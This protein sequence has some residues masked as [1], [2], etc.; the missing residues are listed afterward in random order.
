MLK[1]LTAALAIGLAGLA[2]AQEGPFKDP[3]TVPALEEVGNEVAVDQ[4][5]FLKAGEADGL[6]YKLYSMSGG[7]PAINGA[8][9][10]LAMIGDIHEGWTAYMVGD[11]NTWEVAS[12]A[13]DHVV[14]KVSRS[15]VEQAS[16]E[17]QTAEEMWRVDLPKPGAKA[18][19]ISPAK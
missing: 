11:F 16:G 9:T 18:I 5:A 19:K 15:W 3:V 12:E 10:Y 8:Q 7:D 1:S 6:T 4:I 14:L 13:A 17:I 2:A